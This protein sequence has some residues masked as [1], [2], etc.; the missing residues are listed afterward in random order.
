MSIGFALR[1]SPGTFVGGALDMVNF[2]FLVGLVR[3]QMANSRLNWY[4]RVVVLKVMRASGSYCLAPCLGLKILTD[5]ALR[6]PVWSLRMSLISAS[7][8]VLSMFL[9]SC[10]SSVII[11]LML[12]IRIWFLTDL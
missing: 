5:P 1:S 12:C 2:P 3:F 4:L 7:C 11:E 10:L 6:S 9:K 8:L